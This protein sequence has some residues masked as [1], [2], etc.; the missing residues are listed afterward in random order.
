VR[1]HATKLTFA[2]TALLLLGAGKLYNSLTK[3][4]RFADTLHY[5][6]TEVPVEFRTTS[7]GLSWSMVGGV[8][9]FSRSRLPILAAAG[10]ERYGAAPEIGG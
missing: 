7:I 8:P 10:S 5:G 2:A 6:V 3:V 4:K 9:G 1:P